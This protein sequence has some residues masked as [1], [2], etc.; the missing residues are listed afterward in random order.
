MYNPASKPHTLAL[1]EAIKNNDLVAFEQ[2]LPLANIRGQENGP[3]RTALAVGN[4]VLAEKIFNLLSTPQPADIFL[5]RSAV[6]HNQLE[7]AQWISQKLEFKRNRK[8]LE[9]A[10]KS[11]SFECLQW[12]LTL[13]NTHPKLNSSHALQ[14]AIVH[15]HLACVEIL[16][17][18]SNPLA[19]FSVAAQNAAI[20]NPDAL[21]MLCDV[22]N[23]QDALYALQNSKQPNVEAIQTLQ[24]FVSQKLLNEALSERSTP[25]SSSRKKLL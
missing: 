20:Y 21:P 23:L 17:P 10:A 25:A 13:P 24:S 15:N 2:E 7:S 4:L 22:C 16:I 8:A 18:V 3:L 11:G 9:A 5:L 19:N 6:E 12:L 14:M 1:M